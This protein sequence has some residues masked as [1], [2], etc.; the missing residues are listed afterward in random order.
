MTVKVAISGFGRIGRNILRAL[1]ETRRTDIEVIAINDIASP[2]SLEQLF[3]YDSTH[4]PFKGE[5][6]LDSDTLNVGTGPIQMLAERDPTRASL[7]LML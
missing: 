5:V 1:A 6:T 7:I 4:G 2:E 3:K